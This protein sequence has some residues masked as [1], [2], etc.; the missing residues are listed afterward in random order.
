M[1]AARRDPRGGKLR[2]STE[3]RLESVETGRDQETKM[4][5]KTSYKFG[6][7]RCSE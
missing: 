1:E 2:L 6:R 7:A 4:Q 5:V 3:R